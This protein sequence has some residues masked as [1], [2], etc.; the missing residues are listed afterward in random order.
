M[1]QTSLAALVTGLY[2][3][4]SLLYFIAL[5]G[6]RGP[7]KTAAYAASLAGFVLHAVVLAA[8][9]AR[10]P[11]QALSQ[12]A[13]YFSLMGWAVL[14]I[15][16]VLLWRFRIAF[17]ALIASPLAL[18]LFT[19]SQLIFEG[20]V[21]LPPMLSGLF[22]GLH[23][24]ALF[25][26]LGL[27]AMASAAGAAFIWQE[28]KIKTKAPLTPLGKDLPSLAV[29][30]RANNF[31]VL[32]GFPLFTL[33][34]TSGFIWARYTWGRVFTG[35]PK[36]IASLSIWLAFAFLFHQRLAL[37]WRGRKPAWLAIVIFLV[38]TASLAGIN[39]LAPTHH[40]LRP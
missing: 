21:R 39:F 32:A 40:S 8:S 1:D 13:F 23:I 36:E 14:L 11:A 27:L 37:G 16:F 4:G 29:F 26:S 33:G 34:M 6:R 38:W 22:L 5:L 25:L 17:L 20:S 24:G 10:D 12:G 15:F 18:G 31:A 9:L 30:D 7:V 28:R 2:F 19:S 3:L 35:D